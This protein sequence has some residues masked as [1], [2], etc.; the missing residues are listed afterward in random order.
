MNKY[1]LRYLNYVMFFLLKNKHLRNRYTEYKDLT[2]NLGSLNFNS[3]LDKFSEIQAGFD[4]LCTNFIK[5]ERDENKDLDKFLA[6]VDDNNVERDA[7]T[8]IGF[9]IKFEELFL[10]APSDKAR[11]MIY[12]SWLKYQILDEFLK[13][14]GHDK[15]YKIIK[16]MGYNNISLLRRY[17]AKFYPDNPNKPLCELVETEISDIKK[18]DASEEEFQELFNDYSELFVSVSSR[19]V[20]TKTV[21]LTAA[22]QLSRRAGATTYTVDLEEARN[23]FV[24]TVDLEEA[25]LGK[26]R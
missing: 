17:M 22:A 4:M 25:K 11:E 23:K 24:K 20:T 19:M 5:L 26:S 7:P 21:P 12:P 6:I 14:S 18:K 13:S 1:H 2:N 3:Y 15:R 16:Y 10:S 8:R 9:F